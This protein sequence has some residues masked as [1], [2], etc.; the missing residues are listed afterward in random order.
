MKT[1]SVTIT[2]AQ[3]IETY[4]AMRK[5]GESN[6]KNQDLAKKFARILLILEA[7]LR[8]YQTARNNLLRSNAVKNEHG[9]IAY[10]DQYQQSPRMKWEFQSAMA[11]LE[12]DKVSF[13][14]EQLGDEDLADVRNA[15][16]L[17]ALNPLLEHGLTYEDGNQS[18]L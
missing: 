12:N 9:E 3:L 11:D 5:L 14:C 15:N 10:I 16:M 8:L 2:N 13:R 17:V 6:S 18:Q 4:D 1:Q 7:K